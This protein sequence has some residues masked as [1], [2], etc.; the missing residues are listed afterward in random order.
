[1]IK[2]N[3]SNNLNNQKVTCGVQ[4]GRKQKKVYE[5]KEALERTLRKNVSLNNVYSLFIHSPLHSIY[6]LQEE[7]FIGDCIRVRRIKNCLFCFVF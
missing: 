2:R 1:M 5:I 3:N 6:N 7:I 4:I